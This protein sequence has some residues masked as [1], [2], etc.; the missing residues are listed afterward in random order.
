YGS[1]WHSFVGNV[2]GIAGQMTGWVYDDPGDG[3][4]GNAW[5]D[6]PCIWRL[7]YDPIHWEQKADPQ[8]R[9]T[10]LRE[11]NFDYLTNQVRWDTTA[12]PLPPSLYL[13]AKPAFF[14]SNTWPWVDPTGTTKLYTLPARAR[15][16]AGNPTSYLLTVAT[17]GTGSGSVTSSP[18][19]IACGTACSAS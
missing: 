5:G 6:Q 3:S 9:S 8:V 12:Q 10:V 4:L 18:A 2:L 16:D 13:T 15:F 11:G 1:W 17:A 19:G 7:G 14:G